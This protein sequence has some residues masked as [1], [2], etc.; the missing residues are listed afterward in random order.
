MLINSSAA[1]LHPCL[2]HMRKNQ[3]FPDAAAICL[4]MGEKDSLMGATRGRLVAFLLAELL[5]DT[6]LRMIN[7][8]K[9][10][11]NTLIL[12]LDLKGMNCKVMGTWLASSWI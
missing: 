10:K 5:L 8:L 6:L 3:V 12:F 9:N 11:C 7:V 4:D 1:N 2:S